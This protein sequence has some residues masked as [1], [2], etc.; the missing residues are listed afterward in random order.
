M[1]EVHVYFGPKDGDL[2]YWR[3]SIPKNSFSFYVRTALAAERKKKIAYIP[4]PA[5]RGSIEKPFEMKIFLTDK[6]AALM[7][8][9][10]PKFKR[11]AE[12]K[13]ILRKHLEANYNGY[14]AK[15]Q[16]EFVESEPEQEIIEELAPA[17]E[18]VSEVVEQGENIIA[19]NELDET[20][21]EV[22]EPDDDEMSD[23]YRKMLEQMSGN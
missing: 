18:T 2:T 16:P 11:N 1:K 12:L 20:E 21:T 17:E 15:K 8:E 9:S 22:E 3:H 4:V 5:S 13:R 10:I 6:D 14:F 23:E 19:S 7:M